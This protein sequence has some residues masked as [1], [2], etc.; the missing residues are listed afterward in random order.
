M[1]ACSQCGKSAV[2]EVGGHPLCL[3]CARKYEQL[4]I[5]IDRRLKEQ[6]NFLVDQIEAVTGVYGI[7]PRYEISE[8]VVHTGPMT[9]HNIRVSDS[10]IGAINT[11][12]VRQIDVA[13]DHIQT[14]AT[15]ESADLTAA[16]KEFTEGV[17]QEGIFTQEVQNEIL[18]QLAALT[19][20][21]TQPKESQK[22]GI[23]KALVTAVAAHVATTG[24]TDLW[25]RIA[26]LLPRF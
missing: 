8:P 24:L 3:E 9:F 1:P 12:N 14:R 13:L 2:Y 5:S 15:A 20:Q 7:T 17:L 10:V 21:I 25:H 23:I 22:P 11:G 6:H 19:A 4:T 18:D 26:I 16:L